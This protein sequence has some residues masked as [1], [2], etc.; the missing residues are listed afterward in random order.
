MKN[1]FSLYS[2][3][4][5]VIALFGSFCYYQDGQ[6]RILNDCDAL[7][8]YYYLPAV[9][10]HGDLM[11]FEKSFV[12]KEVQAGRPVPPKEQKAFNNEKPLPDN[13]V[14]DK[15]TCGVAI[16]AS[17]FYLIAHITAPILGFEQN[18]FSPIYVTLYLFAGL[19]YVLWG[20]WIVRKTL[21]L[22]FPDKAVAITLILL[23]LATNLY[24]FSVYESGMSHGFLFFLY[25]QLIFATIGFYTSPNLK[26]AVLIGLCAG[27]ITVIRPTEIIS[28]FIPL[29][30]GINNWSSLKSNFELWKQHFGK[31]IIAIFSFILAGVPH[32]LYWKTVTNHFLYY[33]YEKE[34]FDFKHP[35]IIDGLFSYHNGW[36]AYS[37]I[38][39]LSLIGLFLLQKEEYQERPTHKSSSKFYENLHGT[40]FL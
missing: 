3:F 15:Y 39:A 36:L 38:M 19:F 17:P 31:I 21:L 37:P 8:Y 32:M 16:L 24:Y 18:G 13:H 12:A 28:L 40:G 30:Y 29:L 20:L 35:H 9:V 1:K 6:K 22:Y 26:N 25:A 7:G 10:V 14:L 33:S 5:V 2:F 34:T 11:T 4:T 23:A 27:G